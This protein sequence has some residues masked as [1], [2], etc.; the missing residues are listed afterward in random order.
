MIYSKSYIIGFCLLFFSNWI[1]A[2]T[3]K[4]FQYE[5]YL[6][7]VQSHHPIVFQAFL[8]TQKGEAYITRA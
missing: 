2:Q 4:V 6:E 7:I 3:E 8:K 5:E 1:S